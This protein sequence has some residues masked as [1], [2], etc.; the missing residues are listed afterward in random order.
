MENNSRK[1]IEKKNRFTKSKRGFSSYGVKA[2][3]RLMRPV[4]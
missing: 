4:Q 3:S 2:V 1:R